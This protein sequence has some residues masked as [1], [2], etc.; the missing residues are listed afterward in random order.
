MLTAI[1][2]DQEE[3]QGEKPRDQELSSMSTAISEITPG[4]Q[5]GRG[6]NR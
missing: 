6:D 4:H 3:T 2:R 5:N 1:R